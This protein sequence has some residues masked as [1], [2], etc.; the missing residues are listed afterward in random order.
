MRMAEYPTKVLEASSHFGRSTDKPFVLVAS[1]GREDAGISR[2]ARKSTI[3][4]G[5]WIARRAK[6]RTRL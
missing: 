6:T 1:A 3:S 5:L 2:L 4:E